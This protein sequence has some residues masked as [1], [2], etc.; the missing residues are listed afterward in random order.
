MDRA[1]AIGTE[2]A[3]PWWHFD[4]DSFVEGVA[5]LAENRLKII[6]RLKMN[7]PDATVACAYLGRAL[8]Q[9][10]DFYALQLGG[11]RLASKTSICLR[12]GVHPKPLVMVGG[13]GLEPATLCLEGAGSPFK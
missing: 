5:T 3:D 2:F 12:G 8:H 6:D 10:Q 7:P 9:I 1:A 11:T 4:S 13:A